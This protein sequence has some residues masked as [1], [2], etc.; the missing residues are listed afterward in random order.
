M[1]F[2][3]A[4]RRCSLYGSS[5]LTHGGSTRP[6]WSPLRRQ[7]VPLASTMAITTRIHLQVCNLC[8]WL[9]LDDCPF[10]GYFHSV[11]SVACRSTGFTAWA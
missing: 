1:I 3:T 11:S 9:N 8:V 7:R 6:G 5:F 10:R 4:W 2:P